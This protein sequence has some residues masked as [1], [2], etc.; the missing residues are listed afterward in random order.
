MFGHRMAATLLR[1]T[2]WVPGVR[3]YP[4]DLLDDHGPSRRISKRRPDERSDSAGRI[5]PTASAAARRAKAE[6]VI[7]RSDGCNHL[8]SDVRAEPNFSRNFKLICPV[9]T[10][11]KKYSAFAVGQISATSSRHPARTRGVSRS[12]RT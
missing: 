2:E 12:S 7:H 5:A 6:G 1:R 10:S 9:Q 3:V 11:P 4:P 8:Y